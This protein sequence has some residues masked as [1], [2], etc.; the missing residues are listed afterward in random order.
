MYPPRTRSPPQ[1][2]QQAYDHQHGHKRVNG[3]FPHVLSIP[4]CVDGARSEDGRDERCPP[5]HANAGQQEEEY[6][7]GEDAGGG[8][9]N[10]NT[11]R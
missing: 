11:E 9:H 8:R 2:R 4:Y 1:V 7:N 10:A 3:V 5:A 6:R